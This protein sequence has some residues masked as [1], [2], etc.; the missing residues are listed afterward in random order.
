MRVVPE[1]LD[2]TE[3]VIPSATIQAG[4]VFP[5][6]VENLVH[7]KSGKNRFDQNGGSNRTPRNSNFFLGHDEHIVP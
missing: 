7:L 5:Q 2:A 3:N 1:T 6:L 4:R